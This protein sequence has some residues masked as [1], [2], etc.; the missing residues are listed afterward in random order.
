[1][2]SIQIKKILAIFGRDIFPPTNCL[3]NI[4]LLNKWKM[5]LPTEQ[6]PGPLRVGNPRGW[7]TPPNSGERD[8]PLGGLDRCPPEVIRGLPAMQRL[9]NFANRQECARP[10]FLDFQPLIVVCLNQANEAIQDRQCLLRRFA[11]CEPQG[12]HDFVCSLEIIHRRS[13]SDVDAY[14]TAARRA[15]WRRRFGR[16]LEE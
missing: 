2:N 7:S 10:G 6:L 5:R 14:R 4:S 15:N 16:R 12:L 1:M 11:F 8:P 9:S 3:I 13:P